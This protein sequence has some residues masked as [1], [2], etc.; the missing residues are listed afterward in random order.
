MSATDL[1]SEYVRDLLKKDPGTEAGILVW[2][3]GRQDRGGVIFLTVEDNTGKMQCVVE[4]KK[5]APAQ[6]DLAKRAPLESAVYVAG[7]ISQ[8]GN[9]PNEIKVGNF[10]MVGEAVLPIHPQPRSDIDIMDPSL[11]P[12]LL[13]Y[14][15]LY[16]RNPKVR[17]IL[18]F[19][20]LLMKAVRD[21]FDEK[22]FI[23]FD[24][25][26]LTPA[27]LYNADT[28]LPIKVHGDDAFLSQCAGFYLEAAAMAFDRV[29]NLGPSFRGA[30]SR[31]KRHLTEYYHIKAEM[32]GG[33]LESIIGI[34]EDILPYIVKT[35]K[36]KGS[37]L[38][39]VLGTQICEDAIQT[40]YPRIAYEDAIKYLQANG[41]PEAK[42]GQ[43][44][45]TAEEAALSEKFG[46]KTPVWIVGN[47]RSV[48]P[49]PYV[50]NKDD[51]RLT[52]VA[53]LIASRGC[54]ELLGVAEKIHDPAMLDTRLEEKGKLTDAAYQF[55]REVHQAGCAPH[56]AFGMGLERLIRWVINIEHVRDTIP[57][58]RM[59][60]RGFVECS[61]GKPKAL[62]P[63]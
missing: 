15:H 32:L 10:E 3:V 57:F 18:E 16:L 34:V 13:A 61:N 56:T 55:V 2:L 62:V 42:F 41:H 24:A 51:P 26:L 44:I 4:K 54:G 46:G 1:K 33:N 58:P 21:W 35:C 30:E 6:F 49:F 27:P 25:P 60:G 22:R 50:I 5:V 23:E 11:I 31:S 59:V 29:Y 12:H 52:N 37:H 20:S 38:L 8:H 53:D 17:A 40:P 39:E 63:A 9:K 48:E 7:T 14:R 28:A 45:S 47:P 43:A 36:E 19:R